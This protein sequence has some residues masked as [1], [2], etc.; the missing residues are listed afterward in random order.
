LLLYFYVLELHH[1]TPSGILH[2][3]AFMNL[4]EAYMGIEPHFDLWNYFFRAWLLPGSD[5]EAVVWG[6]VDFFVWSASRVNPYFCFPMSYPPAGWRK[7]W[8]FLRNN[9]DTP[10][11]IFM[12]FRPVPQAKLGYGVAQQYIHRLQPLCDVIQ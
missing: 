8:F 2:I 12:G 11:P 1:L 5:T 7:V 4:C 10:L 3:A 9:T 6:G